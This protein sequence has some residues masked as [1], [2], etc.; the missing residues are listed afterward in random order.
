MA[1]ADLDPGRETPSAERGRLT[2]RAVI[3][4]LS[5]MEARATKA[6][7]ETLTSAVATGRRA[8]AEWQDLAGRLRELEGECERLA[9]SE[10][11]ALARLR[12]V[13]DLLEKFTEPSRLASAPGCPGSH[14]DT[15]GVLAVRMLGS[16]ELTIDRRR[17]AHWQ[18]QRAQSLIQFLTAHRRRH[19]SRDELIMALWP[20]AD[21]DSGRH[22]LHQ[23]VYEL[24]G[25]LRA[26]APDRKPIVCADGGY[27]LD[28]EVPI[29]VDVEA[30]DDLATAASRCLSAQRA[31][32][33]IE[34]GQQA[35]E[36]YRGDFL[37]QVTDADWA[38]PERN[39]LRA[40][41]VQVSIH[42]G[43]LL[44]KRGD[45]GT[46]LTVVD[47]V[48]SME[49]WNEDATVIK[50]RCHAQTGARSMAAAAYR[51]CAEALNCEFGIIPAAQTTRVY[52]QIRGSEP[53]GTGAGSPRS[54]PEQHPDHLR[55]ERPMKLGY[56][57]NP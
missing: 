43:E 33:A 26:I 4:R 21:E 40:R 13:L 2:P 46:A 37:G 30:F 29:W 48:L 23:V 34:L 31:D 36:F 18:G 39:R 52:D 50:M 17:V 56:P 7:D 57:R 10:S 49:P 9:L 27:G 14:Q 47:P 32:E 55:P 12:D 42:L 35:L 5:Q 38:T 6:S 44:T 3:S 19:V 15:P 22:R 41:F 20:D 53:A 45:Q 16:F 25:T 28:R 24:R 11:R 1:A 8:L 54:R 51:S